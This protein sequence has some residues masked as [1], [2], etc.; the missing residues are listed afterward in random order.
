MRALG[1]FGRRTSVRACVV[2]L[3]SATEDWLRHAGWPILKTPSAASWD[4][5]M[6]NVLA[7]ALMFLPSLALAEPAQ[8][9]VVTIGPWQV[10]ASYRA[11]KFERCVMS[12]TTDE[13]VEVR[14]VRDASGLDLTMMSPRWRLDRGKS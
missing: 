3:C 14:F 2:P 13:G 6:R 5:R 10:E 11:S 1:Q 12:R 9:E 4:R 7:L 8:N